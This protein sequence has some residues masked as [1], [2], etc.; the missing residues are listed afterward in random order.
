MERNHAE[1][2]GAQLT[3]DMEWKN[4]EAP[5]SDNDRYIAI[6]LSMAS[7][8]YKKESVTKSSA[9]IDSILKNA[10]FFVIFVVFLLCRYVNHISMYQVLFFVSLT[11]LLLYFYIKH[12][13]FMFLEED[14]K[15]IRRESRLLDAIAEDAANVMHLRD[16][17][18]TIQQQI[19]NPRIYSGVV[20]IKGLDQ[21]EVAWLT[22]TISV[23]RKAKDLFKT[24][25]KQRRDSHMISFVAMTTKDFMDI[26][27]LFIETKR[28]KDDIN[29]TISMKKV[30]G[31]NIC[32][33]LERSRSI[34]RSLLERP[35]YEHDQEQRVDFEGRIASV[36]ALT[37]SIVNTINSLTQNP[38]FL[39]KSIGEQIDS[40][41]LQLLLLHPFLKEIEGLP[42]ES[43]I[44][45]EWV[46]EV[47]EVIQE[48]NLA[49]NNFSQRPANR[50]S[51]WK[52]RRKLEGDLR[53]VGTGFAELLKR[54]ER[55]GFK[56]IRRDSSK[57]VYQSPHHNTS[58]DKIITTSV[59]R[60]YSYL[61]HK[62]DALG[63]VFYEVTSLCNQ[64][65]G[66][67]KLVD[68]AGV[69][70]S[71]FNS[72][73]AWLK[74]MRIIVQSADK[75]VQAFI[76][77]SSIIR[78]SN[79][80]FKTRSGIKLCREIDRIQHTISLV[81]RSIKAYGIELR[82]ESSSVVGLEEDIQA[83]VSQLTT[84]SEHHSVISILGIEGIG[85]TT[86]ANKIFDHGAVSR[87]F[88]RRVWISLPWKSNVPWV[89][90]VHDL[91]DEERYLLVLDNI[92]T[93]DELN[94]LRAGFIPVTSSGSRILFTTRHSDL[95]KKF[96]N[97]PHQLR[98]RTKEES[99]KLFTQ[100]VHFSPKEE[101]LAKEILG[102]CGGF[103]LA[104]LRVGYL[105]SREDVTAVE[106]LEEVLEDIIE[107]D[108]PSLQ[109][110][111]IDSIK[112]LLPEHLS[113]CLSYLKLFPLDFE[114][115]ARR[116]IALWMAEG[117]V[118][119]HG[120]NTITSEDVAGKYLS[121][122]I[123][124]GMIQIVERKLNGEVKTCRLPYS[125][126][127]CSLEATRSNHRVALRFKR[128]DLPITVGE[129]LSKVASPLLSI[130]SFDTREGNKPGE[131]IGN[132][133]HKVIADGCFRPLQVLD[134]ER[135][136]R[137]EFPKAIGKLSNLKY[138]G[139]RWTY[140]QS[141]P[142]FIGD[143]LKLQTLDV[144]HTN[145]R[146]LP[147]SIWKLQKLRHL[148]L[149]QSCRSKFVY[150]QGGSSLKNLQ[151]LWGVFVDKDSP[152]KDGLDKFISLRKLGLAFQ[153]GKIKQELIAEWI[154]KLKH[155]KSLRVRSVGETDESSYI[156]FMS[157][158]GLIN[159]SSLNLI[160]KLAP[161]IVAEFPK[162]LTDLTLSASLLP[163]DPMPELEKLSN[164]KLLCFYS[165]SYTGNK[166]LCSAGGFP[167]L[168]VLKLWNLEKL[169]VWHVEEKAMQS[170]R[171]LE[172]RSC[173]NLKVPSGLRHLKSLIEL[174]LT[175]MPEGFTATIAQTKAQLWD[176]LKHSPAITAVNWHP[177][178]RKS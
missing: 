80:L 140:L 175:N 114:I 162:N 51:S 2:A 135:V 70:G 39:R 99:W 27:G 12:V 63:E 34:I 121:Q 124:L 28:V 11:P 141:I 69:V 102:K 48:A 125:L 35:I 67:Y 164:L 172:I 130:L 118:Q 137:P 62:S 24:F 155:L 4:T 31:I 145:V 56:F 176:D 109:T 136:F 98:L 60:M 78:R 161:P 18:G 81:V 64:L 122:L 146:A 58:D 134:L 160:G 50:V 106:E 37:S 100:M 8:A 9:F 84:N 38:V 158:S 88:T 29:E 46:N 127:V 52:A 32:E 15:W 107:N 148:Y 152:L 45:E 115:P 75:C 55:Y 103:P 17:I 1:A 97:T 73:V 10:R 157:L 85:K 5:P 41:K 49:I 87:H 72:R 165:N 139:L 7:L 95:A 26:E 93:V 151:T 116:L 104:I 112:H 36:A 92:S 22:K 126:P 166:M 79:H 119:V 40:I 129:S 71:R 138:L 147:S 167:R 89:Q 111:T 113:K 68:D 150:Q 168:V 177:M 105:M 44:E 59:D 23:V 53:C 66:M 154:G 101:M 25:E 173:T 169:E 96:N 76:D 30:H 108:P 123:G 61:N 74:Q 163:D 178:P 90:E 144:K 3:T 14:I 6:I 65:K 153:L 91:V 110:Y 117:L 142:T 47:E 171:E 156:I 143:L 131:E 174:K 16:H 133:L 170:L 132:F 86:L 57:F 128:N 43:E 33:S 13:P 77:D 83:L 54:K 42:F 159:L 94:T 21:S 149:N 20:P 82:E 120:N 19:L